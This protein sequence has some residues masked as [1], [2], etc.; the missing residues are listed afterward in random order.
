VDGHRRADV[1][2][3]PQHPVQPP[4]FL[5]EIAHVDRLMPVDPVLVMISLDEH[6]VVVPFARRELL[7]RQFADN[8]GL[9]FGIDDDLLARVSEDP[10]ATF[11]IQHPVVVG[12]V[13]NN[14]AL[15]PGDDGLPEVRPFDAAILQSTIAARRH[16]HLDPQFE[17]LHLS[18][19]P[20]DEPIVLQLAIRR[21]RQRALL[22]L[23]V[24]LFS[25]PAGKI[26]PVKEG[27]ESFRNNRLGSTRP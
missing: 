13:R 27:L 15:I 7:D 26:T 2:L 8:P 4:P 24:P 16:L 25:F 1:H 5:I 21:A 9:C 17:V 14:V 19:A 18:A 11:F 22:D 12:S 10:P 23:P 20:H 6:A 3:H